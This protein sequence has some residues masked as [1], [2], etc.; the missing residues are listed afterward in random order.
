[1]TL[2]CSVFSLY[3]MSSEIQSRVTLTMYTA[4]DN[5]T[6]Q[7]VTASRNEVATLSSQL[8][9]SSSLLPQDVKRATQATAQVI[10]QQHRHLV[11]ELQQLI[12]MRDE[13]D[14]DARNTSILDQTQHLSK[15]ISDA[16]HCSHEVLG[17]SVPMLLDKVLESQSASA[18]LITRKIQESQQQYEQ[19]SR[20][21]S[22]ITLRQ[23]SAAHSRL[24]EFTKLLSTST[25]IR[26][27]HRTFRLVSL[28][29]T[30][31]FI[32]GIWLLL[33]GLYDVIKELL[34]AAQCGA[35][36][37]LIFQKCLFAPSLIRCYRT[38][39]MPMIS[40]IF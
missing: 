12:K 4:L 18:G 8:S 35:R 30:K 21:Q 36:N 16:V 33:T 27:V 23:F 22:A 5:R 15:A 31:D 2:L 14:L 13:V 9:W 24:S 32:H 6:R 17:Y 39:I 34:L 1:V 11:Q 40:F 10:Q 25:F 20:R 28:D 38:I 19:H 7:L 37:T 26:T 29:A 3:F